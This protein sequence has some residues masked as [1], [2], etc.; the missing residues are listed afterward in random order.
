MASGY[1]LVE[2]M[3]PGARLEG[4][5]LT[6][7]AI[8][9]LPR[10]DA[11]PDQPSVWTTVE[12]DFPDEDAE[13]IAHAFSEVVAESGGWYTDFIVGGETFVVFANR[14]FRYPTGDQSGRAEAQA[15]GRSV[16][17]PSTQLDWRD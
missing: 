3:R 8:E 14:I 7:R 10:S 15:Y 6:L 4:L 1:I 2:G 16:G 12:F 17:V 9:R 13:R 5:P 11:S